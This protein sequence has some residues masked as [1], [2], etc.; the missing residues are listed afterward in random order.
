MSLRLRPSA[1]PG[2]VWHNVPSDHDMCNPAH[3]DHRADWT[4]V[5]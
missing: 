5:M 1:L 4:A 2:T 3:L